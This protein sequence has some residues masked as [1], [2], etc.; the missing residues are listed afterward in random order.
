MNNILAKE[1]IATLYTTIFIT[2]PTTAT[3]NII[4]AKKLNTEIGMIYGISMDVDGKDNAN[5]NL[6]TL[7]QS[8]LF[9][10]TLKQGSS[11]FIDA[12]RMDK[13]VFNDAQATGNL[14]NPNRYLPVNIPGDFSLDTSFIV[15][16]TSIITG[17]ISLNL[18]Y[19]TKATQARLQKNGVMKINGAIPKC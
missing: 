4:I 14:S 6:I 3:T 2:V 13:L 8:A 15:N 10:L 17:V 12:M 11:D 1:G 18:W 19:I 7:A 9:Y 16:P 5:N